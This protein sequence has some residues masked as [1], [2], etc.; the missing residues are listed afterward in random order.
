MLFELKLDYSIESARFLPN[1]E[2]SHPCASIHGHS[3]KVTAILRG[4]LKQPEA[5]VMDFNDVNLIMKPI[6]TQL[7]HKLLNEIE[8]LKNPTSENLAYYIF[9]K[10]QKQ[11]PSLVQ[12]RISETRD[13]ECA[14]PAL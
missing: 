14:F 5:W 12:I 8:G 2:K 3:F 13:T 4:P 10:A 7:D 9:D 6:L 11:I 1:L